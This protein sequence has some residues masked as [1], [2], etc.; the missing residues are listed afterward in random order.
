MGGAHLWYRRGAD[1]C[2]RET[3][4]AFGSNAFAVLPGLNQ[5]S[6][7]TDKNAALINL[8]LATGRSAP[9][10]GPFSLTGQPNAMGGREVG[11]LANLLPGH[12][13]VTDADHPGRNRSV[14]ACQLGAFRQHRAR[15]RSKCSTRSSAARSSCSG[16]P[17]PTPAQSL[18]DLPS[19]AEAFAKAECVIVQEAFKTTETA[20]LAD[21][22]ASIDLGRK[23]GTVTNSERRITHL[24]A[25]LPPPGEAR[26]DWDIVVEFARRLEQDSPSAPRGRG[27]GRL[28]V[29][30]RSPPRISP[31]PPQGGGRP[32]SRA[33]PQAP[34]TQA[35]RTARGRD[36][37]ITGPTG[38]IAGPAW[39]C[40]RAIDG[41]SAALR[42]VLL[43]QRSCQIPCD[44]V[45]G[46]SRTGRCA[47]SACADDWPPARPVARHE[48]HR[49]RTAALRPRGG[50][51]LT[52]NANDIARRGLTAGEVVRVASRRGELLI[53][54]AA[55]EVSLGQCYVPM[56]WGKLS[57]AASGSRGINALTVPAFDPVSKQ[58]E[59][60]HAA[61]RVERAALPWSLV[62]C[63]CRGRSRSGGRGRRAAR[64]CARLSGDHATF[65]S[66]TLIGSEHPNVV[67]RL[68]A[69]KARRNARR[70][71]RLIACWAWLGGRRWPTTTH[72]AT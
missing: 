21:V 38:L 35:S 61:V 48:P 51:M 37:D 63:L 12:R 10:A 62:V 28:N 49:P 56:H 33:K 67:L 23:H 50:P 52:M 65:A 16:L 72:G 69:E 1:R 64:D 29:A 7:G 66:T 20:R 36:A 44:A 17:A 22:A 32:C 26:H 53:R 70:W 42:T 40:A 30:R 25:V 27:A 5:S 57:L 2:V 54:L 4:A 60:K 15:R 31:I 45:Q 68:A 39:H 47:L 58:P 19:V 59:L 9:G 71:N 11:G 24:N 34:S 55:S 13:D 43:P 46:R 18:P 6:S 41:A 8:H 14:G 3:L